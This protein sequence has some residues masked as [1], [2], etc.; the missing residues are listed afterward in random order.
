MIGALPLASDVPKMHAEGVR[1]VVNMCEEYAG[2]VAAYESLGMLQLR[3]KTI[4]FAS[5]SL[6]DLQQGVAFIEE[7]AHSNQTV[8]IHC[9]AG[10]G[11]SATMVLCWL[12]A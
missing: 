9:K 10:R 1:A 12:V 2:P 8:Y 3:L 11:R 4:D 5:P 7:H 6:A